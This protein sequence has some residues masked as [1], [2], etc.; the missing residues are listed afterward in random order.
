MT[1]KQ[2]FEAYNALH[3]L[4]QQP[5]PIKTAY[6]IHKLLGILQPEFDFRVEAE[7]K[8]LDELKPESIN[9]TMVR[10]RDPGDVITWQ[11]RMKEIDE[12]ETGI[13]VEPAHVKLSDEVTLAP[14]DF[15]ALEGF[16]IFDE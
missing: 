11:T 1:H 8:L 16:V 3:K 9:G 15:N 4:N 5:M 14:G 10:F 2:A 7:K 6:Q 13:E 12:I